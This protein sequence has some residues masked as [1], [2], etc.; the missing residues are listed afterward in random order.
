MGDGKTGQL[1]EFLEFF[2][3]VGRNDSPTGIQNGLLGLGNKVEDF[4]EFFVGGFGRIELVSVDVCLL[5]TSPS[6]RDLSTSRM[7]S[8]A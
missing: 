1:G 5:Y 6:P 8:S 4:E 2:V 7:P 3:G